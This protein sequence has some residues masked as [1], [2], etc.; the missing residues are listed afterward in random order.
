MYKKSKKSLNNI[1]LAIYIDGYDVYNSII[2][3]LLKESEIERKTYVITTFEYRPDLIARDIYGDT[4]Y[5]SFLMLSC[6]LAL[7]DLYKG[8]TLNVITPEALN[9]IITSIV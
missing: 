2:L 3:D 8:A 6:S 5:A 4:K 1:D 9:N 7:E